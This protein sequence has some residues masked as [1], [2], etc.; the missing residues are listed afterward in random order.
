MH[1]SAREWSLKCDSLR[2]IVPSVTFQG[3]ISSRPPKTC[4]IDVA[5]MVFLAQDG[6][7]TADSTPPRKNPP[8]NRQRRALR[9]QLPLA[10][11]PQALLEVFSHI[12]WQEALVDLRC[13]QRF[14]LAYVDQHVRVGRGAHAEHTT[15]LAVS[16]SELPADCH[17]LEHRPHARV[18]KLVPLSLP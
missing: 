2:I 17:L 16:P 1:Q 11:A 3:G 15:A 8:T 13:L 12:R 5:Q 4:A 14:L 18:I 9:V 6:P 7:A 10:P